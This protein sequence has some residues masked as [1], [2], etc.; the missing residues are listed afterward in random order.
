M[1]Q[2]LG[3]IVVWRALWGLLDLYLGNK[4]LSL[5]VSLFVGMYLTRG[6]F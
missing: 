1:I 6:K 3:I 2:Q 5:W 4:Q